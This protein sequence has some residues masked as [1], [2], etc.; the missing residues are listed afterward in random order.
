MG[1]ELDA[2]IYSGT[3][4]LPLPQRLLPV[5]VHHGR[6]V[7]VGL[8]AKGLAA[9]ALDSAGPRLDTGRQGQTQRKLSPTRTRD[10]V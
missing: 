3:V 10:T 7:V 8:G 4:A 9:G 5:R 2:N 6:R 1:G